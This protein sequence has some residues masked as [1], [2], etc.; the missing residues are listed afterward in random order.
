[1][2]KVKN[3]PIVV[4][5]P[6]SLQEILKGGTKNKQID[7]M[8]LKK[9]TYKKETKLF[10]VK[11]NPGIQ[12]RENIC[13]E[14]DGNR[15]RDKLPGD[16]VFVVSEKPNK[17]FERDGV[18]LKC[19][20]HID[21]E[22]ANSGNFTIEIKTLENFPLRLPI[23]RKVKQNETFPIENYGFPYPNNPKC[24][25]KIVVYFD[26]VDEPPTFFQGI[27]NNIFNRK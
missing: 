23:T 25:G 17:F 1:M 3:E 6:L 27:M 19:I 22:Q 2:N 12:T 18:D 13:F 15:S 7:R 21:Y 4:D 8:V 16:V 20:Y 24:R 26:I 14:G 5:F 11:F 10:H 9:G